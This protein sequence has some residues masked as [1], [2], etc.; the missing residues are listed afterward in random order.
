MSDYTTEQLERF[1]V[2][3][4]IH[5][6]QR[7]EKEIDEY[8]ALKEIIPQKNPLDRIKNL[9]EI[10]KQPNEIVVK[11]IPYKA[12]GMVTMSKEGLMELLAKAKAEVNGRSVIKD[13][14]WQE[15]K[16][17]AKRKH[18]ATIKLWQKD[19]NSP[20][21]LVVDWHRLKFEIDPVSHKEV[22]IFEVTVMYDD[23]TKETVEMPIGQFV[24]F[25][26]V[27][28]VE[29]ES[30]KEHK[31][32]MKQGETR[33]SVVK[34]DDTGMSTTMDNKTNSKVP[35]LVITNK[36]IATVKRDNGKTFEIPCDRLNH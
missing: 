4:K 33:V 30:I 26:E 5:W 35:L 27:E 25:N 21:G 36:P 23:D 31:M 34:T 28:T 32:Q 8:A 19:Y 24:K 16:L 7:T 22:E 14:E 17:P 11:E 10:K 13:N 18:T 20:K 15:Y 1:A 9:N 29:I 2:L 3:R 12:D 6:T